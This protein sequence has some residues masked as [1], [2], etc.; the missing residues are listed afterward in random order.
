MAKSKTYNRYMAAFGPTQRRGE[1][2]E[3]FYLD[4]ATSYDPTEALERYGGAAYR[5]FERNLGRR[6]ETLRGEQVGMGRLETGFATEDEDYLITDLAERYQDNLSR[7][8]LGASALELRN[9]E[10][11][12]AYGAERSNTYLDLL[13][14]QL[15]RETAEKNA[16][17]RLLGSVFGSVLGAAGTVAGAAIGGPPGAA[18]GN[19]AGRSFA[20]S[21]R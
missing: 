10:G 3:D 8:A 9:I 12:G 19:R 7:Q 18:I 20:G 11:V 4:E 14:G 21:V 16:K 17:K 5:G 1:R 15:D 2:A 6:M 13:S